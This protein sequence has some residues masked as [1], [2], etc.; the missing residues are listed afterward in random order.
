VIRA[1][2]LLLSPLPVAAYAYFAAGAQAQAPGD[3]SQ[4]DSMPAADS[5]PRAEMDMR[6]VQGG[7]PPP[8][9]RDPNAY[10]EGVPFT[11]GNARTRLGDRDNFGSILFDNF[12]FSRVGGDTSVPYDIEGWFGPTYDR[13]VLKAEGDIEDGDFADARTE[14]LWA[15]AF[16]PY[17]DTQLGIRHDG[18]A[19]TDRTW[20]AAG[21]EGLAPYHFHLEATAYVGESS[22]T[23]IRFDASYDMLLTQ[24]LILQPRLEANVYGKDDIDRGIGSGLSD[25][26]LA[27]RLRYEVRRELAPYVGVEWVRLFGDTEDYS[28]AAGQDPNDSRVVLGLRFWF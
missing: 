28:R 18:G 7:S 12:E 5:M 10:S 15:H 16:A 2:R 25:A 26:T 3:S 9:A 11:R 22:R 1:V 27:L 19:G 21:V 4:P 23:A 14:L 24:R 17:W 20:L 6:G 8:D 13:A